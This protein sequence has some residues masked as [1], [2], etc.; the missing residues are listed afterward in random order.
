MSLET[1]SHFKKVGKIKDAHGLRGDLSV[2]IFSK[3]TSWMKEL[4]T[5]ALSDSENSKDFQIFSVEKAKAF[6]DGLI[7]KAENIADRTQA[8]NLKGKLFFIPEELL[9]SEE[10]ETIYLSEIDGFEIQNPQGEVLGKIVGFTTNMAQDLLIVEK[11]Q[12]GQAEIPFVEN[13]IVKIDF[14][15]KTLC[16][17]LPEGIWDLAAL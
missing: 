15:K 1:K 5:F 4:E 17:D 11:S 8:E 9:I 14:E 2:L 16:L 7:L 10:G 12:G 3:D 13:F 6:K